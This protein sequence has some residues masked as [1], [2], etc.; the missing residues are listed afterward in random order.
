MV[1]EEVQG[2]ED[3][4]FRRNV[5]LLAKSSMSGTTRRT[6]RSRRSTTSAR[7]STSGQA[8]EFMEED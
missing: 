6:V 1:W 7:Y 2:S 4:L 5:A 8:D 3:P